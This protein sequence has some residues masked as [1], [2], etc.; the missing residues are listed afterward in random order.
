MSS[1]NLVI[2]NYSPF[3]NVYRIILRISCLRETDQKAIKNKTKNTWS[4]VIN[5]LT[6]RLTSKSAVHKGPQTISYSLTNNLSHSFRLHCLG[7]GSYCDVLLFGAKTK[8]ILFSA[9]P[10]RYFISLL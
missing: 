10:S 9:T 2:F 8:H 7:G 4:N 1:A 6:R 3:G 5:F